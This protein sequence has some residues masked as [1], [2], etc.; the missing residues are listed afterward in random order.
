M[1]VVER[2]DVPGLEMA[3]SIELLDMMG[4]TVAVV[5]LP[6]SMLRAQHMQTGQLCVQ[7]QLAP[8]DKA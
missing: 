4:S 5:I 8:N 2:H 7:E 3:Y 1:L 6:G